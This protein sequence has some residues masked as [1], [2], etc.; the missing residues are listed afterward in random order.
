MSL[1]IARRNSEVAEGLS[2]SIRA[3]GV[4][5]TRHGRR[6]EVAGSRRR[7]TSR[8]CLRL[9]AETIFTCGNLAPSSDFLARL[10]AGHAA[11]Y[12]I[13]HRASANLVHFV[14]AVWVVAFEDNVRR[15]R[16]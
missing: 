7:N 11:S 6:Y 16:L 15:F 13:E 5:V 2:P 4:P 9:N 10:C 12:R 3:S 14:K 1:V 8:L